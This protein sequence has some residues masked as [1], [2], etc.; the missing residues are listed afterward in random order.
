ME[1]VTISNRDSID[2]TTIG[3]HAICT[4]FLGNKDY[5]DDTWAQAFSYT[6]IVDELLYFPLDFLGS[7][8]IDAVW[9]LVRKGCSGDEVDAVFD[10]L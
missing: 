10:A 6:A 5:R 9:C 1:W 4:I 3:T 2:R 8:G 7:F